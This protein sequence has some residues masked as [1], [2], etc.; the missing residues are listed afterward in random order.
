MDETG[1]FNELMQGLTILLSWSILAT[2]IAIYAV[3]AILKRIAMILKPEYEKAKV[4]KILLTLAGPALGCVVAI[5]PNFL[6]GNGIYERIIAGVVA[7]FLSHYF[8]SFIKRFF[9]EK[10]VNI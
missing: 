7:G 1:G 8:Y 5:H 6:P 10:D 9:T 4:T 2:S 3:V